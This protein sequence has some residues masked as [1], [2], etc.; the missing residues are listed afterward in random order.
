MNSSKLLESQKKQ[1]VELNTPFLDSQ[2]SRRTQ[3]PYEP[4]L[5]PPNIEKAKLHGRAA[6]VARS[7][8]SEKQMICHCCD[9]NAINHT[10]PLWCNLRN[11]YPFRYGTPLFFQMTLFSIA[12]LT[13]LFVSF[14][15]VSIYFNQL[16]QP[17]GIYR[18]SQSF[19]NQFTIL[20][21]VLDP[22]RSESLFVEM[23]LLPVGLICFFIAFQ[24]FRDKQK[25]MAP[26]MCSRS[27]FPLG[28]RHQLSWIDWV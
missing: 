17:Q 11:L 25:D 27:Y 7:L 12:S 28:V 16:V 1:L 5:F 6:R 22:N 18:Y 26:S 19:V 10:L 4:L 9:K 14:G 2:F 15:A 20:E 21:V 23:I 8:D 24:Q 3:S 13:F